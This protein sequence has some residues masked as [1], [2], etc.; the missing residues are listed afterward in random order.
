MWSLKH[1]NILATIPEHFEYQF[2][3]LFVLLQSTDLDSF[4]VAVVVLSF[5][6]Y[7]AVCGMLMIYMS[8]K[9]FITLL[10][11]IELVSISA[12]LYNLIFSILLGSCVGQIYS[13]F[14]LTLMVVEASVGLAL[15][16]K[17]F[18]IKKSI[19]IDSATDVI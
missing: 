8:N 7:I 13:L 1:T 16:I 9:D 18:S 15:I 5:T 10:V 3:S 11:S 4:E 14:I 6:N 17:F 2:K 19:H 12:F